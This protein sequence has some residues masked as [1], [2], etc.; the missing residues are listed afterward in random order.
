MRVGGGEECDLF[1]CCVLRSVHYV[2]YRHRGFD[3]SS[4]HLALII[5]LQR[6]DSWFWGRSETPELFL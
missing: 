5:V 6:D 2:L 4:F 1:A 3:L